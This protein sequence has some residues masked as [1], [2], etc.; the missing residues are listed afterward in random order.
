MLKGHPHIILLTNRRIDKN[1]D[2]GWGGISFLNSRR[3][4][5]QSI[6]EHLIAIYGEYT[7]SYATVNKRPKE[8]QCVR[9]SSR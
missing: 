3:P 6:H 7:P 2:G 8:F 5:S 1:K 9:K 4:I